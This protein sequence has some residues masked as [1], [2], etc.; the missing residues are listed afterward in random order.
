MAG[1]ILEDL[2]YATVM[3]NSG[4]EAL[5]TLKS[6]H[7]AAPIHGIMMDCQMPGMDGLSGEG[8][9]VYRDVPII[10]LTANAMKGD[11]EI[12]LEAGM[13]GYLSKPLDVK[14]LCAAIVTLIEPAMT[15]P[16]S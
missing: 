11:K 6:C 7:A 10:A 3:A 8:S 1:A 16:P 13:N 5:D 9:D 4:Q 14:K 2:G 12:C 15:P